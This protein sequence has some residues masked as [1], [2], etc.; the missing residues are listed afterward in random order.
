M[1]VERG[2]H[3][4]RTQIGLVHFPIVACGALTHPIQCPDVGCDED[5]GA[6]LRHTVAEMLG[7]ATQTVRT[8]GRVL[9]LPALLREW[10]ASHDLNILP[11]VR[12]LWEPLG[13]LMVNGR[14]PGELVAMAARGN[15]RSRCIV[16]GQPSVRMCANYFAT[17]HLPQLWWQAEASALSADGRHP[18]LGKTKTRGACKAYDGEHVIRALMAS[19]HLR[20]QRSLQETAEACVSLVAPKRGSA[21]LSS[22]RQDGLQFPS[23]PTLCRARLR[24]DAA[25]CMMERRVR[26]RVDHVRY[27]AIDASPVGGRELLACRSELLPVSALQG[28]PPDLSSL[29][30]STHPLLQLGHG[31]AGAQDKA[32]GLM[33]GLALE[34]GP[35]AY[36]IRRALQECRSYIS[37]LGVEAILPDTAVSIELFLKHA[38]R[39][40]RMVVRV[41][42]EGTESVVEPLLPNAL[43]VIGWNHLVDWLGKSCTSQLE[44]WPQWLE[45]SRAVLR[46][47]QQEAVRDRLRQALAANG[48]SDANADELRHFSATFAQWRWESLFRC[49]DELVRVEKPLRAAW[50]SVASAQAK[51]AIRDD[52]LRSAA[53]EAIV[54][55]DW[56]R[57]C[58]ALHMLHEPVERLRRWGT[59]CPCHS[60]VCL[61]GDFRSGIRGLAAGLWYVARLALSS[62]QV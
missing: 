33:H 40:G 30:I 37:D 60:E 57:Q 22:A 56:W 9:S 48:P 12:I 26:A 29:R 23:Q 42:D 53:H 43:P 58:H 8:E 27:I 62:F 7:D 35:S 51:L 2:Q 3:D 38:W 10:R 20:R 17:V 14:H 15:K 32:A 52:S 39:Q 55:D 11:Y 49:A 59:G 24:L 4:L 21:V 31:Q 41:G 5:K 50:A 61:S 1:I 16:P 6:G 47:L 45:R 19:Q 13:L 28:E 18:R 34:D 36:C 46:L 25:R 54:S 44:F